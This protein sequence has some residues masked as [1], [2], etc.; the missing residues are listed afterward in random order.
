M[1]ILNECGSPGG[2]GVKNQPANAG[3][4]GS[5]AGSRRFPWRRRKWQPTPVFLPQKFHG[6]RGLWAKLHTVAKSR[7]RL[8]AYTMISMPTTLTNFTSIS[9]HRVERSKS[10]MNH[11]FIFFFRELKCECIY[12]S[13][14]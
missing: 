14:S 11:F 13:C 3:D 1:P 2:S 10:L 8:S 7:T 5:S 12:L 4:T 6:Q 9:E